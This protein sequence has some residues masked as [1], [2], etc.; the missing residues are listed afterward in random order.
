MVTPPER[1]QGR[2]G[3]RP[4]AGRKPLG[5]ERLQRVTVWLSPSMVVQLQALG[6]GNASAGIRSLLAAHSASSSCRAPVVAP[7]T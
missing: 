7:S 1:Q 4:G 3:A 6:E 5:S 2:G